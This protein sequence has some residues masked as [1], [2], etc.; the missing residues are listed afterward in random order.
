MDPEYFKKFFNNKE[1]SDFII[2][3][4]DHNVLYLHTF[5]MRQNEYFDTLFKSPISD[6]TKVHVT[7]MPMAKNWLVLSMGLNLLSK[8]I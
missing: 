6:K 2:E 8:T 5:I 4:D 3:D 7:N 1:Y